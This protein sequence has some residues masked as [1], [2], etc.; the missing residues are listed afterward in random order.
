MR[1]LVFVLAL[2]LLSVAS[3]CRA[4]EPAGAPGWAAVRHERAGWTL[5]IVSVERSPSMKL[6]DVFGAIAKGIDGTV[7]PPAGTEYVVVILSGEAAEAATEIGFT[8]IAVIDAAGLRHESMLTRFSLNAAA[9]AMSIPT[10]VPVGADIRWFEL[11]GLRWP[12]PASA[13]GPAA[14]K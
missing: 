14:S 9:K 13:P 1:S 8:R 5:R 3:A 10:P 7:T 2:A 4:Q 11:D 12:L 6:A